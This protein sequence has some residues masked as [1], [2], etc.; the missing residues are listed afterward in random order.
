M[1]YKII[2]RGLRILKNRQSSNF[3][4]EIKKQLKFKNVF[5]RIKTHD[6]LVYADVMKLVDVP[7]S[8]SGVVH[9]TCRFDSG[10]RHFLLLFYLF[11]G[12]EP[13]VLTSRKTILNCFARQSGHRHFLL[14]FYLFLES[15][16]RFLPLAKQYLIVL[17]GRVASGIFIL[18]VILRALARRIPLF[19]ILSSGQGKL[20]RF[21]NIHSFLLLLFGTFLCRQESTAKKLPTDASFANQL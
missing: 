7:D 6:N 20:F 19:F 1:F 11:F 3:E 21:Y 10:H 15:N 13:P 18:H 14:L 8:K 5:G 16:L 4:D 12:V 17:L 2:L 9:P